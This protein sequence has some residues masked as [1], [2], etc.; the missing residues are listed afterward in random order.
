M[1]KNILSFITCL[2]SLFATTA[3]KGDDK[4]LS[5]CSKLKYGKFRIE[6]RNSGI[7]HIERKGNVQYEH[8]NG[9]DVE[10]EV[11]WLNECT[12]TLKLKKLI[13][14]KEHQLENTP[15]EM[16]LTVHIISV[17]REYY[18]QITTSNTNPDLRYQSKVWIE[19]K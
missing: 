8:S 16:I 2:L 12:Y 7:V 5:G 11:H 17:T 18:E 3:F 19:S 1:I 13:N 15:P 4:L 9:N 14:D 6:D 10:L